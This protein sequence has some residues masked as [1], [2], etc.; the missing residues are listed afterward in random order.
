M[1]QCRDCG[2]AVFINGLT[3]EGFYQT[4]IQNFR[5]RMVSPNW[6]KMTVN[7]RNIFGRKF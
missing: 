2:N 4:L 6:Y 7:M 1:H 5:S 3:T